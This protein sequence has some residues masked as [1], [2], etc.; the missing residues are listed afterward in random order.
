MAPQE[1][2]HVPPVSRMRGRRGEDPA[3]EEE[4]TEIADVE[5]PIEEMSAGLGR[6]EEKEADE[7]CGEE[8]E[9]QH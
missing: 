8:E 1:H 5:G 4:R 6:V 9:Q 2:V 7:V 3:G